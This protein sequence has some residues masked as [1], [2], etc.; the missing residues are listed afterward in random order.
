MNYSAYKPDISWKV[1]E[2]IKIA[3]C[4]AAT[5]FLFYN[6]VVGILSGL[7][8][9]PFIWKRDKVIFKD[10]R[11]RKLRDEFKDAIILLSG[12][13]NAGYSLENALVQVYSNFGVLHSEDSYMDKELRIIANG[14]KCNKNVEELFTDFGMRCGISEISDFANLIASAKL[15]G[16]NLIQLIRQA[17]GNL[18]DISMVELEIGTMISAKRLEGKIMLFT[19]FIIL[20][21]MRF[22][23]YLYMIPLYE[24]VSGN[25]VMSISLA[26]IFI[27]GEMIN[28]MIRIEV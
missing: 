3:A 28:R 19:P 7:I 23:N 24:T 26:L 4:A 5:A 6:S 17:A 16:G 1:I 8:I 13:L 9:A 14:L 10:M 12:N 18:N 27:S 20:L 22:T 21:Y 11:K 15:Y 2:I 25:I